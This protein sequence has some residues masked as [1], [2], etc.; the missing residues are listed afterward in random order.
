MDHTHLSRKA[1]LT[2]AASATT[3]LGAVPLSTAAELPRVPPVDLPPSAQTAP[4]MRAAAQA[5]I[6]TLS[7]DQLAR[8]RYPQV[9][10]PARTQWSNFPAGASPRAGIPIDA[11]TDAQRIALHDLLRASTS[12]QGYQKMTGAMRADDVLAAHDGPNAIGGRQLFGAMNYYVS[13]YGSPTDASWAWMFTGHHMTAI[14]TVSR[15]RVAFTPMFT[16]AQPL[17]I[18][19]GMHAGWQRSRTTPRTPASSS[20][21]FPQ[22]SSARC[23]S[24]QTPRATS[25]PVPDG[26]TVLRLSKESPPSA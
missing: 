5:F 26:R 16:G 19:T 14:F 23:S 18:A 2:A 21:H 24:A 9:A 20:H 15:D 13:V 8:T 25:S 22:S 10:D 4:R 1:L 7:A 12:S 3:I 11:L 17:Q 6:A